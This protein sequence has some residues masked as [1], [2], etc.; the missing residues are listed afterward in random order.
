MRSTRIIA[1]ILALVLSVCV[2]ASASVAFAEGATE[3]E[4]GPSLTWK[5]DPDNWTLTVSG[6]GRMTDFDSRSVPWKEY[7]S[8]IRDVVITEGV[9]SIG[10]NA[11]RGTEKLRSVLIPSTVSV[12]GE[13]AFFESGV[14]GVVIPEGVRDIESYSFGDLGLFSPTTNLKYLVI[15]AT[16][17]NI[18]DR[19]LFCIVDKMYFCGT[20]EQWDAVNVGKKGNY[21]LKDL[22]EGENFFVGHVHELGEWSVVDP[23]K[24]E[25]HGMEAAKCS[26]CGGY[27]TRPIDPTGHLHIIPASCTEGEYCEDCG[28]VYSE[29]L[30]HR[31][32]TENDA[33]KK[34]EN[35]FV[36]HIC[37]NC[38]ED[39]LFGDVNGDGK[40]TLR[41][42]AMMMRGLASW[43]QEGFFDD[44]RDF[45]SDGKFNSRDVAQFMRAI[46]AGQV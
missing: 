19:G 3:G 12:I 11:F 28:K 6:D 43:D 30:R 41:D 8:E 1:L 46:A 45:N 32:D 36:T 16:V 23:A 14:Q 33:G 17:E 34:N 15:P 13:F 42:V 9:T 37:L 31:Y 4:C 35:G 2:F 38:G 18:E 40:L 44:V 20:K 26:V 7:I 21:A 29:K 24:C 22:R 25:V 10:T 39:I 27:V 5:Y